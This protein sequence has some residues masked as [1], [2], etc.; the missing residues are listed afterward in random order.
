MGRGQFAAVVGLAGELVGQLLQDVD[1]GRAGLLGLV[2]AGSFRAAARPGGGGS[3][4]GRGGSPAG[5][6]T[7]RP[8]SRW[9]SIAARY[10]S[11]ASPNSP[12]RWRISPTRYR[13]S[14]TPGAAL[15]A[16][17]LAA[18]ELLV[19]GQH[20]AQELPVLLRHLRLAGHQPLDRLVGQLVQRLPRLP[21]GFLLLVALG[22]RLPLGG[23]RP[24]RLPGA[25]RRA[26]RP[27]AARTPPP[28]PAPPGAGGRTS[29]AGSRRRGATP[30]PARRAGSAR[31][32]GPARRPSRSGGRGPS[33]G[34]SSRSSPG[35]PAPARRAV[36]GSTPRSAAIAGRSAEPPRRALGRGGSSSRTR[37]STSSRP[38]PVTR[39]RLQRRRAGQQLVQQDA[40]RVDVR[41]G[42][43]CRPGP[44]PPAP[45]SCTPACRRRRRAG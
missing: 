31:R 3:G 25:D 12:S 7:R 40:E 20:L 19:Q 4:P 15:G 30:R 11:S 17:P 6:G 27:G 16:V 35:R 10:A 44:G 26:R 42:C 9:R 24:H 38:A 37:R 29:A 43:R 34:T 18:G 13:A 1:G 2:G 5:R 14:A 45:G 22:Q 33:P 36:P 28:R 23:R 8:A 32:P 21:A 39:S 41:R